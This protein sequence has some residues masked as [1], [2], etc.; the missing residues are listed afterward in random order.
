MNKIGETLIHVGAN[1]EFVRIFVANSVEFVVIGGLA[2]AWYC[3]DRQA[4]DMDL[5]VNPTP[6]NSKR[7]YDS[8]IGLNM[9]GFTPDSFT[10]LGLQVPLKKFYYAELLTPQESSETYFEIARGCCHFETIALKSNGSAS[11]IDFSIRRQVSYAATNVYGC[12]LE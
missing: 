3:S 5:L 4:D 7:I 8:L 9:S 10:K 2:V 12:I 11:L 6:Q 1:E